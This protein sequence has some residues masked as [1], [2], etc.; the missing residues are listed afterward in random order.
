[1]LTIGIDPHK[2]THT[3]VAVNDLGVEVSHRTVPARPTGN[4]QLVQWARAFNGERVWV[5]EDVRYVRGA[6]SGFSSTAAKPWCV[7][8]RS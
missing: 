3:A 8:P 2:Q 7:W 1:M 4:G 6:W 5:I